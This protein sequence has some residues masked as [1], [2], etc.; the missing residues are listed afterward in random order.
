[1]GDGAIDR[2]LCPINHGGDIHRDSKIL[3]QRIANAFGQLHDGVRR[4]GTGKL[5]LTVALLNRHVA[6]GLSLGEERTQA[7]PQC[8]TWVERFWHIDMP[9]RFLR[10]WIGITPGGHGLVIVLREIIYRIPITHQHL[11]NG[12]TIVMQE[13]P[14]LRPRAQPNLPIHVG[15]LAGG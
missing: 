8:L 9:F 12:R 1:M 7:T 14:P 11:I 4:H 3:R 15:V 13:N 5:I 10:L 2:A 6:T